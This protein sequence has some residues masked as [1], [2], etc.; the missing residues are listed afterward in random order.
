MA[1]QCGSADFGWLQ[2]KYTF[3]FGHYFDPKFLGFGS[4]RVLNQEV[5]APN[6]AFQ[7]KTYPNVDIVN[8]I[9]QG[10]TEIF[11]S[12]GLSLQAQQNECLLFSPRQNMRYTEINTHNQTPL[13]RLQLWLNAEPNQEIN[14][15]QKLVLNFNKIQLIAS[16]AGEDNSLQL[17]QN[18]WISHLNLKAGETASLP[19]KGKNAFYQSINGNID[20]DDGNEINTVTCGD[21]AFIH[22]SSNLNF[23]AQTACR[24]LVIDVTQCYSSIKM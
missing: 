7:P 2:A 20:V 14:L 6:S 8:I 15:G 23:T 3:S 12:D 9:L 11:D 24:A 5:I 17:R 16:P 18:I 1:K 22:N 10:E 4:L 13:T 21:G 19:L